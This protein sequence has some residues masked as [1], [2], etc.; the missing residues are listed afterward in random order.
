LAQIRGKREYL[1]EWY[2]SKH[3]RQN[4][5]QPLCLDREKVDKMEMM[6]GIQQE[7][8]YRVWLEED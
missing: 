1:H 8:I 3:R 6:N 2:S 4:N 7:A 5:N